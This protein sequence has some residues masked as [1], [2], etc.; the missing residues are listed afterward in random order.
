MI[1]RAAAFAIPGD[2]TT[3]TGGYIYERRLL[4]GLRARGHDTEHI[5]LADSFPDPS[6]SDM[7]ASVQRLAAVEPIRILIL[8]GLVFG[9]IEGLEAVIAPIVAMVHHPLALE[10]GLSEERRLHL[11]ETERRNL[12]LARHVLVP[13]RHTAG[14]LSDQYDVA[15]EKITIAPPGTDRPTLARQSTEPPLILTVGLLHPRKGH[16]VLLRALSQ[17][18]HLPWRSVIVGRAHDPKHALMLQRLTAE[19]GLGDRVTF[20]GTVPRNKLNHLYSEAT[21]FALATRYEGHGMVFDEAL[22]W[23]LP[24]VSCN[25]GAVLDTVPEG[26]GVLTNSDDTAAF[27]AALSDV[28]SRSDF[29]A[30][31]SEAATQAGAARHSW[32]ETARIASDALEQV[33]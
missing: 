21:V 7:T 12:A 9:A 15:P 19:L 32:N 2:I 20:A 28:L 16:D 27:A 3:L 10:T 25:G 13:S 8:D 1:R 22:S 33:K 5:E 23:G 6:P 11:F 26:C 18:T 31:L 29:R 4:L 30:K 14:I 17:I 24:I